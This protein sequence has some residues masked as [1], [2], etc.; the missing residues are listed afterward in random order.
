MRLGRVL[1]L[2]VELPARPAHTAGEVSQGGR[3]EGQECYNRVFGS[4]PAF[5]EVRQSCITDVLARLSGFRGESKNTRPSASVQE[6][7]LKIQIGEKAEKGGYRAV[8]TRCS[9]MQ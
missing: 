1:L 6:R 4:L 3:R 9:L 8:M 7:N 5:G 2:Y